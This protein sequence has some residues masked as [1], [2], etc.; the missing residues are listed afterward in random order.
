MQRSLAWSLR[1]TT[2]RTKTNRNCSAN[3]ADQVSTTSTS[4][5]RPRKSANKSVKDISIDYLCPCG[6]GAS[7]D[8]DNS[9]P[10]PLTSAS[11]T[12]VG[13]L[14]G[15]GCYCAAAEIPIWIQHIHTGK[16]SCVNW[17][18]LRGYRTSPIARTPHRKVP[19]SDTIDVLLSF[20]EAQ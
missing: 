13:I 18:S 17:V 12:G 4:M 15:P 1:P 20:S 3:R 9:S 8:C 16:P 19:Q 7:R 5:I 2:A 6:A 11:A 14:T 10:R